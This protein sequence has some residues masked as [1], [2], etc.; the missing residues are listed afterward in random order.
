M[1]MQ[2]QSATRNVQINALQNNNF[3]KNRTTNYARPNTRTNRNF[4]TAYVPR[5]YEKHASVEKNPY[6]STYG[7]PG[8]RNFD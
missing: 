7:S 4:G 6:R 3:N 1:N 5:R 2:M 8:N